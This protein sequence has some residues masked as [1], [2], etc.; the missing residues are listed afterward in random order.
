MSKLTMRPG[1]TVLGLLLLWRPF[2]C[3]AQQPTTGRDRPA[4][5]PGE[6]VSCEHFAFLRASITGGLGGPAR[7]ALRSWGSEKAGGIDRQG[8]Y[9]HIDGNNAT[10]QRV[11]DGVVRAFAG[12]GT[13]GYR[14]G[15]ADQAQFDFGVGSYSDAD[16]QCDAQGNV[17]VS[18]GQAGRLR[19][20]S[21]QPDGDW[22]V[23]TVAG[24]GQRT[25]KKG[26]RSRRRR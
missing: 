6:I 1:Y 22:M 3:V 8:T 7:E 24:G 20:I 10:I 14:D 25:L 13:R 17:Y 9:Y 4:A 16:V 18:E 21:R 26:E 23:S 15:P 12:D 11:R 19:K 5:N 2:F